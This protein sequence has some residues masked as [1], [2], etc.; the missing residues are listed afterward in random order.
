[1][2]TRSR[3]N[4]IKSKI[5]KALRNNEINHENFVTII[6]EEKKYKELKEIIQ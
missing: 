4:S 6:D 2:L 1:M 3:Q 5:S